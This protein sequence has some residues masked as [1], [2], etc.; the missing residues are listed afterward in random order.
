MNDKCVYKTGHLCDS[1]NCCEECEIYKEYFM[2][3]NC[4]R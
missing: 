1:V 2:R 3:E 4:R